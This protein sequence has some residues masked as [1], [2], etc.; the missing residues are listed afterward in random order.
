MDDEREE[1]DACLV[2]KTCHGKYRTCCILGGFAL[3][4]T[5][6]EMIKYRRERN[7]EHIRNPLEESAEV[8]GETPE[9]EDR[10]DNTSKEASVFSVKEASRRFHQV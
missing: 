7:I 4:V 8:Q 1:C 3:R 6:S 2:K 9:S 10:G 5:T